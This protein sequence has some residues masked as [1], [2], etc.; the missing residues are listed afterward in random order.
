MKRSLFAAALL[1][2]SLAV[3][4]PVRAGFPVVDIPGVTQQ[5]I[6]YLTQ[7][8][9]LDA[10]LNQYY[11]DIE[12]LKRIEVPGLSVIRRINADIAAYKKTAG[13]Y[14]ELV[15]KYN[16]LADVLKQFQLV[17]AT[18][19]SKCAIGQSC[20]A[21][22]VKAL[23]TRKVALIQNLNR[24]MDESIQVNTEESE[25]KI[26]NDYD[27]L[28]SITG[29]NPQTQGEVLAKLL[30]LEAFNAKMSIQ[31]REQ[32][33]KNQA[34]SLMIQRYQQQ[35]VQE[36][37]LREIGNQVLESPAASSGTGSGN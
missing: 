7:L 28:S 21:D 2:L 4:S 19:K 5:L 20:S 31:L 24:L 15:G 11:N 18:L 33:A 17:E 26:Q 35:F 16:S 6:D 9:Q 30:E 27:T 36:P 22:D 37:E 34:Q 12:R 29:G 1:A 25:A 14:N 10:Q 32:L 13:K 8:E 3:S 23:N